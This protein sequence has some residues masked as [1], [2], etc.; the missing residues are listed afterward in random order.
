MLPQMS[1]VN[2]LKFWVQEEFVYMRPWGK[3]AEGLEKQKVK[4][5]MLYHP[6][7]GSR[8]YLYVANGLSHLWAQITDLL[9]FCLSV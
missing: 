3:G 8:C 5:K 6:M 2:F 1:L 4:C 7:A 9:S